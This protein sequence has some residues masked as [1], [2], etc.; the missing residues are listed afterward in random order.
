MVHCKIFEVKSLQA[1]RSSLLPCGVSNLRARALMANYFRDGAS[2]AHTKRSIA[3][4][5]RAASTI[6]EMTIALRN[7]FRSKTNAKTK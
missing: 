3:P 4:I 7:L 5:A 6:R 2:L 1:N